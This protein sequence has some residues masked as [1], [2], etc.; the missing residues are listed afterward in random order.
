MS[1]SALDLDA[2]R[3]SPPGHVSD[4]ARCPA[5]SSA[6]WMSR[7]G[8]DRPRGRAAPGLDVVD[9]IPSSSWPRSA[10][11]SWPRRSCSYVDEGRLDVHAP[12]AATCPSSPRRRRHGQRLARPDAHIRPAGHPHRDPAPGAPI[13]QARSSS[14]AA[15]VPTWQPGSRYEYNSAAWVLLSETM[16][17]LSR[18]PFAEALRAAPDPTAGHGGHRLRP[19]PRSARAW[20]RSRA[21]RM[22]QPPRPGDAAALPGPRPAARRR[23]LRDPPGPAAPGPR[24]AAGRRRRAVAAGHLTEAAI[25]GDGRAARQTA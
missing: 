1:T 20:S 18:M 25:D 14:C 12:L 3:A 4:R 13:Y 8:V 22:R 15:A 19:S 6:S 24:P 7:D 21:S 10:R 2:A 11:P 17:R 16:A 9:A 5:S 23:A